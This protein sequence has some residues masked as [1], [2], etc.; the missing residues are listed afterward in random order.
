MESKTL[1]A[2]DLPKLSGMI[3]DAINFGLWFLYEI[4]YARNPNAKY[5]LSTSRG[6]FLLTQEGDVIS[7][8]PEKA[9]DELKYDYK[10]TFTGIPSAPVVNMPSYEHIC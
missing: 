2:T 6:E 3:K 8:I 4:S 5:S 10:I 1:P 9:G 7:P